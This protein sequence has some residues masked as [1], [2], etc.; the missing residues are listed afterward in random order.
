MFSPSK[1]DVDLLIAALQG[2]FV[3]TD[4]GN[5]SAYLGIQIEKHRDEKENETL[6]MSQPHLIQ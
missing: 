6:T 2:M 5:V 3:L 4:E 1:K